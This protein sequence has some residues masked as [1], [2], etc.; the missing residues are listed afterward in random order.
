M[1]KKYPDMAAV[2]IAKK[3][4]EHFDKNMDKVKSEF[5]DLIQKY[6]AK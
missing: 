6:P 5:K 1:K 2:E 3:N 4:M